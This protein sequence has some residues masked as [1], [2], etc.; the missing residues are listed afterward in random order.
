[1]GDHSRHRSCAE[2]VVDDEVDDFDPD[3]GEDDTAE[4]VGQRLRR[5]SA[6]APN[7]AVLDA[8]QGERGERG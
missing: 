3:E 8:A 2:E 5:S 4:A 7:G 1:M 6:I